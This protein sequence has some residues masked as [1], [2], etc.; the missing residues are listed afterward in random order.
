M[1]EHVLEGDPCASLWRTVILTTEPAQN[2]PQLLPTIAS[3]NADLRVLNLNPANVT[4][5]R[6]YNTTGEVVATY[7]AS[8]ATEF[9]FKAAAMPGYYMVEVLG[10]GDKV[11][12]RYIVK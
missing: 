5:I 1:V 8:Q 7:T 6:V 11:T 9:M 12:L 10:E 3:P 2:A 4:E